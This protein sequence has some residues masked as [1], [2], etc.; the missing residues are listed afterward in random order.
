[1]S[2]IHLPAR[3]P[4]SP[5]PFYKPHQQRFQ[6][7]QGTSRSRLTGQHAAK[8]KLSAEKEVEPYDPRPD[9]RPPQDIEFTIPACVSYA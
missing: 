2:T 7:F 4:V 3:L 9:P 1:M 8:H 5:N 6:Q